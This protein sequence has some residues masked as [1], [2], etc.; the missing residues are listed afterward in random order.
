MVLLETSVL[1]LN[2]AATFRKTISTKLRCETSPEIFYN[3]LSLSTNCPKKVDRSKFEFESYSKI[4]CNDSIPVMGTVGNLPH[5]R[6][7]ET[8]F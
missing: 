7:P 4:R 8:G 2:T 6:S 5:V 1:L 3:N